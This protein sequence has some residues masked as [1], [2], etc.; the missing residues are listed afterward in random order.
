MKALTIRLGQFAICALVLT[1]LFRY[2]LNL[3]VEANSVIGTTTCSI[4][5][6]CLMFL[7]G[8]YFGTKDAKENE[9]HDIG[10]RYHLVTYIFSIGTGYSVHY[11]GWNVESLRAMTITAISWGIG[12]LVHFIFYLI[13]Q[14]KT[15]KGYAKDEIFQ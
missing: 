9:V 1:V 10:F 3:S 6:G 14:R 5:Y 4:V 8:W 2:A 12:L 7:I 15:I 11:L 13:E